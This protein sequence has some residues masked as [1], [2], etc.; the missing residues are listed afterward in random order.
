M[1]RIYVVPSFQSFAESLYTDTDIYDLNAV[2]ASVGGALGLFLGFSFYK[3]GKRLIDMIAIGRFQSK[4]SRTIT[5]PA[6]DNELSRRV[7]HQL[8]VSQQQQQ[9]RVRHTPNLADLIP[10]YVPEVV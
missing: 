10:G 3:C 8:H 7:A 2:T 1:W 6:T 5:S 4:K 9:Q